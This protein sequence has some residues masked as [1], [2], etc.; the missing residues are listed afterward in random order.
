MTL[1]YIN[2]T[3]FWKDPYITLAIEPHFMYMTLVKAQFQ[4]QNSTLIANVTYF[5]EA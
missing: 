5:P 4:S 3:P 1:Q 2:N